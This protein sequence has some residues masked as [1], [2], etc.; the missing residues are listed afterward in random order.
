MAQWNNGKLAD[1]WKGQSLSILLSGM[2]IGQ[3][4]TVQSIPFYNFITCCLKMTVEPD[5]DKNVSNLS[6][7]ASIMKFFLANFVAIHSPELALLVI[8]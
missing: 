6:E 5:G 2:L 7:G 3:N 4:S 8:F 1:L